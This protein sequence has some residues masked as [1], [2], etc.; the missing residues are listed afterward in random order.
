M[1]DLREY[2][3][4][5]YACEV[6]GGE[7]IVPEGK[8]VEV[9]DPGYDK[10]TWCRT[11]V[12]LP[13]GIYTPFADECDGRIAASGIVREDKFCD[14]ESLFFKPAGEVG[15]DAGLMGFFIDKPD[16]SDDEWRALCDKMQEADEKAGGIAQEYEFPGGF[17][18]STGWGDGCYPVFLITDSHG[19]AC[20]VMV[21]YMDCY[22]DV[23]DIEDDEE[24]E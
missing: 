11:S 17:A 9:T 24:E 14:A 7:F 23:D 22:T 16:F 4:A 2:L 5:A 12:S 15:V 20:G 3:W 19:E 1:S 21:V 13:P 18:T 6:N 8:E 10:D